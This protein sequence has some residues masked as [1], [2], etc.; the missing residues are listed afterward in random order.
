MTPK[1]FAAAPWPWRCSLAFA[2]GNID[3]FLDDF[4]DN[5]VVMD[6]AEPFFIP[7]PWWPRPLRGRYGESAHALRTLRA[8]LRANAGKPA[9]PFV[10]MQLLRLEFEDTKC[11]GDAKRRA[12]IVREVTGLTG[13]APETAAAVAL[14]GATCAYLRGRDEEAKRLCD[15]SFADRAGRCHAMRSPR[16]RSSAWPRCICTELGRGRRAT[17]AITRRCWKR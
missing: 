6:D 3:A 4:T 14:S 16:M 8:G 5:A 15:R 17:S 10:A 12:A 2:R 1:A 11:T 9:S 7:S 13:R